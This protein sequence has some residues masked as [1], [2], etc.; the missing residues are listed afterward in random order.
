MD[1]PTVLIFDIDQERTSMQDLTR[2][3]RDTCAQRATV[4]QA[5][6]SKAAITMIDSY[7]DARAII[8]LDSGI[9][10]RAPYLHKRLRQ[11]AEVGGVVVHSGLFSSFIAVDEMNRYWDQVWDLPWIAGSYFSHELYL[12]RLVPGLGT[13]GLKASYSQKA[14]HLRRVEKS[15]AVYI[16]DPTSEEADHRQIASVFHPYGNGF[17]GYTGDVN[18]EE[19]TTMLVLAMC[20]LS[21]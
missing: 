10:H 7:P 19:G 3:L 1:K 11:Y 6:S 18:N 15:S 20:G 16:P 4:W 2:L 14:L 5:A 9:K 21:G 12:N 17:V 13:P 8:L